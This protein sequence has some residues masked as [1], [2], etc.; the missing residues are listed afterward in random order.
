MCDEDDAARLFRHV[1]PSHPTLGSI[2]I[3]NATFPWR[4]YDT[5]LSHI[6]SSRMYTMSLS[7]HMHMLLYKYKQSSTIS[8]SCSFFSISCFMNTIIPA[9]A[10]L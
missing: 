9:S 8:S 7:P 5:I 6:S 1:L 3:S 2:Q 4:T 10:Y